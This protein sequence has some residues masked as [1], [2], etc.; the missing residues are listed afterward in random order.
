LGVVKAKLEE[1]V[2]QNKSLESGRIRERQM[3]D[4]EDKEDVHPTEDIEAIFK[5][6]KMSEC[7]SILKENDIVEPKIF[8]S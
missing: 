7:I 2:M 1:K 5:S 8:Y 4:K 6:L 3:K